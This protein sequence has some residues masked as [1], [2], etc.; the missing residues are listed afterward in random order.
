M[1]KL[2]ILIATV[3]PGYDEPVHTVTIETSHVYMT[4]EYCHKA[5][6]VIG[7]ATHPELEY[8]GVDYQ[9]VEVVNVDNK[10]PYYPLRSL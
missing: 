6:A 10:L 8:M 9:C 5:A 3:L 2:F 4:E 7:F 1:F